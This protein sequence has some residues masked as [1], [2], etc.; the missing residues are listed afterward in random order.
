MQFYSEDENFR[1][2]V[3]NVP[4]VCLPHLSM[5]LDSAKAELKKGYSDFY[6]EVSAPT[7]S[8]FDSL[9]EDVSWFCKKFDYRYDSEPWGNSRDAVERAG[10]FLCGDLHQPVRPAIIQST[11]DK[12]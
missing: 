2:T 4:Y 8:Y 3:Q 11:E 10:R 1:S 5:W 12:T 7:L 6:T 9:R